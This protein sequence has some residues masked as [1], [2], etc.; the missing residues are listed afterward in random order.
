[1]GYKGVLKGR[2]IFGFV[3]L[4]YKSPLTVSV[5]NAI[6]TKEVNFKITS[7]V[8]VQRITKAKNV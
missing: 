8:P 4:E 6:N 1:M 3:I 5:E 7:K 2:I